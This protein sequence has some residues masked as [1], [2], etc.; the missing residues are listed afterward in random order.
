MTVGYFCAIGLAVVFMLYLD[1]AI[2]VMMLAFLLLMPLISLL[3]TLWVR[4]RFEVGLELP[5]STA[6]LHE[7]S[8]VLK[9]TKHTR[10]PMPF[11]RLQVTADAHFDPLNP[12]AEPL[13]ERPTREESGSEARYRR[14]LRFWKK[15]R[16]TQLSPESLPLCLSMGF[17]EQQSYRI[18]L[19]PRYCG[20]AAV[21]AEGLELS[22]YLGMFRFRFKKK[23]ET[24][25]PVRS[26][27]LVLPEIPDVKAN[28]ALFRSVTNAVQT[29]D[30]ET[31][32]EPTYSASSAPGY[33]HRDYIPGDPLKR[34]N[35]KLSS[36]RHHLMVRQDEPIVLS[37]LSV[38][39][40]FRRD[41]RS[42]SEKA[43]LAQ[44]EQLIETAL[45]FLRL[46][47]EYGYPCRLSYI[48]DAN[49]WR[50]LPIDDAEHLEEEAMNMLAGGFRDASELGGLPLLPPDLMQDSGILLLYFSASPDTESEAVLES[51]SSAAYLIVPLAMAGAVSAPK[52]GALWLVT[53]ERSLIPAAAEK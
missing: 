44:E 12:E 13:P 5:D 34:I 17:A 42:I 10:L 51:L 38:V 8:A 48:S 14:A 46:C 19:M 26:K 53:A 4:S 16:R 35:W 32:A 41:G 23:G 30:D 45:G 18:R 27:V 6:K 52:N 40:D 29:A 33:E 31:E 21:T 7:V 50:S 11:L 15:M 20:N 2:G 47:A 22:D 24:E 9:V 25:K 36:K 37:R 1:G 49:A 28:S 39:I 3:A 43:R